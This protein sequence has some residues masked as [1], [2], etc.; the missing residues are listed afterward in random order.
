MKT[1]PFETFLFSAIGVVAMFLILVAL[2]FISASVKA[3]VDLTK[4]KAYTLSDG[5][6]AIL[7]KL[8]SPV[9][10]RFYASQPEQASSETV[11][12][13]TYAKRVED[14]LGEFKQ[15]AKDKLVIEKLDPQPDSDAE[16]S[17]RLDGV[18]GQMLPTGEN[19]YLGLA[20]SLLD[21]KEVVALPPNEE[22]LLEYKITRAI[23]RVTKPE[24]PVVGVMSGLPV[25]GMP[26]NPM[27]MRMGQRGQEPWVFISELKNDFTVRNVEMTADKIDDD[28]KLLIVIH[29]KQISDAAQYALDQF[30]L[31][32]GKLIAFLDAFSLVDSQGQRNPMMGEMGGGTST[33]DKL[34]KAWGLQFETGKVVA[35]LNFK[36]QSQGRGNRPVDV[37]AALVMTAE[38]IN[39][40]DIA[41]SEIDNVLVPFGGAFTGTP[42]AGLKETVLLHS[43][44]DSK[45]VEGFLANLSSES[46]MKDFKAS[47]NQYALAVK[48]SGRFKTAFPDGKP[49]EKKDETPDAEK[50]S[51]EKKDEKK[52]D[53]SLKESA[54][55]N[56]VVLF[57]DADLLYDNFVVRKMETPF[58]NF[59]EP[60]N[61]NLTLAQN[62]VEQMS[63][64]QSLINM[65]SRASVRRPFTLV[66]KMQTE[67]AEKYQSKIKDLENSLQEAQQKVN[68]LQSKKE[69]GQ[70][71]IL[72]PE[73][74]AELE[75]VRKK[76]GEVNKELKQVRKDL[77]HDITSLENRLKWTNIAGMPL[78][79]TISGILIAVLKRKRTGAK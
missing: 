76:Q 16:D 46:I 32:G 27:M 63:G 74:Q 52:P 65:R 18:E 47:G 10:I 75:K 72:S 79:V 21:S 45:L 35:D 70:R 20:V 54:S 58:G 67:A 55:E 38:G 12:L 22:R 78:A 50:K 71:F 9:K 31:R 24:K 60:L 62:I 57:G 29:P 28:I 33:L 64:D 14:L 77:N 2:N 19:F 68:E 73:Q 37:P 48:L 23:T 26:S 51:D 25:F 8:D 13:K 1:K 61:A 40:E 66:K 36:A 42:A 69:K 4:E 5:T 7:R 43:T 39:R 41:T 15:I 59:V 44:K 30:V 34:L 11:V 56:T 6:K 3:R 17:A 49:A 53:N